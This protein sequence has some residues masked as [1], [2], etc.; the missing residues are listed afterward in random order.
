MAVDLLD[1]P[2]RVSWDLCSDKTQLESSALQ[3]VAEQL[4]DAGVFFVALEAS[5]LQHPAIS[6]LLNQLVAGGCQVSVTLAGSSEELSRLE[7]IPG[8]TKL[9]LDVA[10]A[11]HDSDI[12]VAGLKTVVAAVRA[13]GREPF[14]FWTPRVGQLPLLLD[15]LEFCSREGIHG[16]KLPNQK[17]SVNSGPKQSKK[18]PSCNDL[19]QLAESLRLHG[20]PEIPRFQFEVHDLFLWELLQPLSGGE[21]SEYGGCQAGNSLAHVAADGQLWPCSSW[22]LPLGSL[23][24]DSLL[25]LWQN[26]K[27]FQLRQQVMEVPA[28]CEDCRDYLIC[29]G[30]CRGL[31]SYCRDDGLQRDL[32]CRDKR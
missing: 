16:F 28:G 1:A 27:R 18:L 2:L 31:S 6:E 4:L 10:A 20:V 8:V 25:D 9:Y 21:R 13:K 19:K 26:E 17:I 3:R 7:R 15:M 29:Y 23:L 24:E 11:I 12:D 5:P 14:L 22:P 30:G 32:L